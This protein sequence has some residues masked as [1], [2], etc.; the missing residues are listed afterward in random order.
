[1]PRRPSSA[2]SNRPSDGLP[3]SW[4]DSTGI[5]PTPPIRPP[6]PPPTSSGSRPGPPPR[7]GGVAR[8]ASNGTL[9]R[10]SRPSNRPPPSGSSRTLVPRGCG[11]QLPV[12]AKVCRKILEDGVHRW[13][14]TEFKGVAPDSNAAERALRHG[15]SLQELMPGHDERCGQ[16]VRGA[17][18]LGSAVLPPASA[19]RGELCPAR[20]STR[21][22]VGN[23][24][25]RRWL[26]R[27]PGGL[28]DPGLSPVHGCDRLLGANPGGKW[29]QAASALATR[30][31]R[32][33]GAGRHH[34][35]RLIGPRYEPGKGRSRP[36]NTPGPPD[37]VG[38]PGG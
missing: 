7:G 29:N 30:R 27:G 34:R 12:N 26:D 35:E 18:A 17:V 37:R 23:R 21:G 31:G 14:F 32:A 24:S 28:T 13:R 38:Q 4:R 1:M 2:W 3:P 9:V 11:V 19:G 20:G 6:P 22:G 15:V 25:S 16:E 5:R 36:V 10:W 8:S 33:I